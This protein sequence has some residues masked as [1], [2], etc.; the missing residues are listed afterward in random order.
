MTGCCTTTA[1]PSRTDRNSVAVDEL[2]VLDRT[3]TRGVS[4]D[5]MYNK[6]VV[7]TRTA[8]G[9]S[10]KGTRTGSTRKEQLKFIGAA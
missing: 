4:P 10:N 7:H 1:C 9:E 3:I 2:G 8:A 6:R 5:C